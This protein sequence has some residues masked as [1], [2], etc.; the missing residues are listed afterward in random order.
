MVWPGEQ[1]GQFVGCKDGGSF[2]VL[3]RNCQ[4]FKNDCVPWRVI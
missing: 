3:L 4:F 2:L 1:G